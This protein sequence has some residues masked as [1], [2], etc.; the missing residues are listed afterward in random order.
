M[1]G[2][3]VPDQAPVSGHRNPRALLSREVTI[4]LVVQFVLTCVAFI[5]GAITVG[6]LLFIVPGSVLIVSVTLLVYSIALLPAYLIN[7]HLGKRWLAAGVAFLGLAAVALL[8]HFIDGYLLH[9]L[10]ASDVSYPQSSFQPRSFEL[11]YQD[12]DMSWT[13]WRGQPLIKPPP[14]CADLCQQLLFEGNVDQV[15]VHGDSSGDPLA[16]GTIV[17]TGAK[18]YRLV[19]DGSKHTFRPADLSH[20]SSAQEIPVEQALNPTKFFKPRWRRFR[21]Q[22]Q[23]GSCPATPS[24]VKLS[25]EG[26]CLIEDVVDSADADV[27]LSISDPVPVRKDNGP[28]DPCEVLPYR[29]IQ[30]GPTTVTIAERHEGKLIPVEIKTT[31]V[32]RYATLPFYFSVRP[33]G[34]LNLCLG[35][36]SDPFPR[37]HADPYEMISRRYGLAIARAEG[38]DRPPRSR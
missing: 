11:P 13:N 32:A 3:N 23:Q 14:P 10:V 4:Y 38:S 25:Q 35:V 9:R 26:R 21:L 19:S 27:V 5:P 12:R 31:L 22:Q 30:D 2:S 29:G 18:A 34:Q 8:P 37:S 28:S 20:D 33:A 15:F 36:A 7:R 1:R 6:I 16:N 17:I 24:I